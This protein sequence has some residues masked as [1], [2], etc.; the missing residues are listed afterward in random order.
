MAIDIKTARQVEPK[1]YAYTTPGVS[2]HDG[3]TKIGY[4]ERDVVQRIREQTHTAGIRWRL[5]W[6]GNAT[7][8]DGKTFTDGD[9]HAYLNRQGVERERGTEWFQITGTQ[10]EEH[11]R[12]FKS[13]GGTCEI[14]AQPYNLRDEQ[15]QAVEM[16]L[17]Y[18]QTHAGGKFLWNAKPRFGKTLAVYDLCRRA[19]ATNILI[20]T[21][22]PAIANSWYDDY[23]KFI[24][25]AEYLFVSRVDALKGRTHVLSRADLVNM[26]DKNDFK[27]IEFVSLQDMKTSIYFGGE[28]DKLRHL[29]EINWDILVID[30]AHEGVDTFKTD[31]A[32]DRIKRGFTLQLSGTP[33]KKLRSNEFPADAI[34]NWTYADEQSRKLSWSGVDENPYAELPR[35]NLFTYKMS[36]IIADEINRGVELNG[37]TV[38]YAFDLN[39]FF[40]TDDNGNFVHESSVDKFLNALTT[41]KKFPFS[42]AEL[43]DEL[44]HT[45]WLLERVA[46]AKAL[47]A[48]LKAHPTF[49]DYEIVLAA[50]DGK[51]DDD[52]VAEKSFDAVTN[53][54]KNHERTI[55][56]SV[57]QLTAG[58]TIPQWTGVLMLAN[59]HSAERY[60]QATFRAQNPCLFS[61]DGKFLRKENAYVFDFDPA[62]TLNI[63]EAFA[64]DLASTVPDSLESRQANIRELLNFFPV[65]GEDEHGEMIELDAEKVLSIPREIRSVEVVNRGF[66]SDFLFQNVFHVFNLPPEVIEIIE[67]FPAV[68]EEEMPLP[69]K[70][71]TVKPTLNLNDNTGEIEIPR[72]QI[73]GTAT[74]VFGEK[75]YKPTELLAVRPLVTDIIDTAREH[76]GKD[77]K[78][79]QRKKLTTQL[80]KEGNEIVDRFVTNYGIETRI[81]EYER[82]RA[83]SEAKANGQPVAAVNKKFDERQRRADENFRLS[84]AAALTAFREDAAQNVVET[85]ETTRQETKRNEV[86][87]EV[88]DHLRGFARTIP[89]FLMAYGDENTTLATFDKII[90]DAV[91]RE[92]TSISLEQFRYLRDEGNLFD[93]VVFDDAI[94]HFLKLREELADY[95][96]EGH[97][98]DIFDYIPPQRTNQIF[99]PKETVRYMADML[100]RE[101]PGCFDDPD[102]TFIDPYMKSGLFVAELVKRLYRS[103]AL[104]KFFPDKAQR[105]RHIF[106]QQIYALAPTEI[107]YRI[108]VKYLLGFEIEIPRNNLRQA[109]AL[110]AAV[111]D[112]LD[113]FLSELFDA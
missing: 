61:R 39:E 5:E 60:I 28:F 80:V 65:I 55:T 109:N 62:R 36:D 3:W 92:V 83:V 21:N 81:I 45:L 25:N 91:F 94:K 51:L 74:E 37:E 88:R 31:V 18:W 38:E 79:A 8:T 30:E 66:M 42:T 48:K 59:T 19:G 77:L 97:D 86:T 1:I 20:V 33:F 98:E 58:V 14:Q 53:A 112:K 64:N 70:I 23:E 100:E 47:A 110:P 63:Y 102:K 85:V 113:E 9:F 15:N 6:S 34:F 12:E 69:E 84:T 10:S 107:I 104:K 106:G 22:R 16:T 52:A 90:P 101:S 87:D 56:L 46:S 2:Y 13:T 75:I 40:K 41:Q 44:R 105:L 72:T 57:G 73:I 78:P 89:S 43:R 103:P 82:D 50:G 111:D 93:P 4:T 7:F 32:F 67:A 24:G 95:F 29:T 108:A 11:F 96:D 27:C 76:Y 71:Q 17:A 99:T 35:L 54:I 68:A 26:S 49:S